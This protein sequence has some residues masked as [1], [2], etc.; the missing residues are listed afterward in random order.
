M[1]ELIARI[2]SL[3]FQDVFTGTD[4][5]KSLN[6]LKESQYWS[7]E[8]IKDYQSIK[9]VS[10]V[11]HC[12]QN[13]PYYKE[14]FDN[15]GLKPNDI[16]SIDD[17]HRIPILTKE[18]VQLRAKDL[19]D[20][21]TEFKRIKTGKTGGTTGAPL[22]F[23]KDTQN[24]SF[25]WASYYRWYEWMG[26][27]YYSPQ[28]TFWGKGGLVER[29]RSLINRNF[30]LNILQNKSVLNSFHLNKESLPV[31]YAKVKSR[32]PKLLKGYLSALL[33]LAQFIEENNLEPPKLKAISS[34]TETLLP[35]NREYLEKVFKAPVFDQYGCGELS[36]I[37]YEC[38]DHSG[39]HINQEHIIAEVL[40]QD[41]IAVFGQPGR[42]VGTDLDNYVM[43]FLRYENGDVVEIEK[44]KECPCGVNQP[45][46]KSILGRTID[47]VQLRDG[48]RVHGVFF[49]ILL[50]E[51]GIMTDKVLKFQIIQRAPEKIEI[52]LIL[53]EGK[54][55][56]T[57]LIEKAIQSYVDVEVIHTDRPVQYDQN[58]KFRYILNLL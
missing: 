49:T 15:I 21:N 39:L 38:C 48:S 4:I 51:L 30:L 6:F 43:P 53:N 9:L 16:K 57:Q 2:F 20:K 33:D 26:L 18:T 41:D 5:S 46:I 40:N 24:R 31:I 8:K 58:G 34:T 11:K 28:L 35:N 22:Q 54:L 27:K 25:T 1:M 10:L 19:V 55:V 3:R 23:Y 37:A 12:Y 13:V 52:R 36:G 14:K 50:Y 29:K 32:K 7:L 45:K 56:N 44:F 47:T 17:L 42:F